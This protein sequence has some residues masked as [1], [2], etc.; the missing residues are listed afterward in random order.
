MNILPSLVFWSYL[1]PRVVPVFVFTLFDADN[2]MNAF[3]LL[4]MSC[5]CYL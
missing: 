1:H 5:A 4:F 2:G 3:E